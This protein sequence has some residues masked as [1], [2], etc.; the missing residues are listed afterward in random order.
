MPHQGLVRTAFL[1]AW[2]ALALGPATSLAQTPY[3]GPPPSARVAP[4]AL[5][6]G[7]LEL[8]LMQAVSMGLENNLTVEVQRHE[9]LIAERDETIAWGAYDPQL[10]AEFGW[11]VNKDPNSNFL[12]QSGSADPESGKITVNASRSTDGFAG[13]RGLIPWL[14]SEYSAQFDGGRRTSNVQIETLS[15]EYTSSFTLGLKQPLLKDFIWNE[16][17]TR[18][19]TSGL[20]YRESLESFRTDVMDT[21]QDIEDAYWSLIATRESLRVA[22][23][24]LDT[25]QALL[26][27]VETQYE[28]G[29]VSKV[30][31]TEAVAGVAQREFEL[32]RARN[33]YRNSQDV[34]L[35]LVLGPGLKA[36]ST[37]EISPTDDPDDY[38][39]YE[40]DV[41]KAVRTAF[42]QRPEL[43]EVQRQIE[44]I[45]VNLQFAKS[46]RLPQLDAVLSYSRKGLGGKQNDDFN[47]CRAL[48]FDTEAEREACNANPPQL[49]RSTSFSDTTDLY[50]NTENYS[51]RL[52]F[53]FPL[54]NT[55]ARNNVSKTQVELRRAVTQRRRLEQQIIVEVRQRA[56]NLED[57]QEG[58]E[59]AERSRVAAEEQLRAERIRLEYG[60]S[61]PF[62]VLQREEELVRA[63]S[64]EIDAIRVYRVSVTD[65]DRAQGTILRNRNIMIDKVR[66]LR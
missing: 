60:E 8:S 11:S 39:V 19:K 21:V 10:F 64:S 26:E 14:S 17:W 42:E 41:E 57:S 38:I 24:S 22:Q 65:L 63:E 13:V 56:R 43:V 3:K 28:V 30:A 46:Q 16:E 53:S 33:T 49:A 20:A 62:D 40:I 50:D 66:P 55:S 59:A 54:T 6:H 25:A 52:E 37:L 45:E 58:I 31:V 32:I 9:P 23:K 44:Q 29:V 2:I 34:L 36:E 35:D 5:L 15:P 18:V 1:T 12:L 47:S 7:K 48:E 51:A 27:Q 4:V 61:T